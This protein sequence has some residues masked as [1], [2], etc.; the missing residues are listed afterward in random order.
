MAEKVSGV[1]RFRA[2][3]AMP[4]RRRVFVGPWAG[5]DRFDFRVIVSSWNKTHSLR[6][7]TT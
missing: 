2:R 5:L 4:L 1:W 3:N 6:T 7:W